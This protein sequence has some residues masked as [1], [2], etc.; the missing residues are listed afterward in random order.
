MLRRRKREQTRWEEDN[1]LALNP[2]AFIAVALLVGALVGLGLLLW[3][4]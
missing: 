4:L 3:L 2:A 1:A